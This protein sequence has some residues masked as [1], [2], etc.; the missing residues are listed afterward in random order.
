MLSSLLPSYLVLV[1]PGCVNQNSIGDRVDFY[2]H[3]FV[4]Y[5]NYN[6][7]FLMITLVWF[8]V[9]VCV[10]SFSF[11]CHEFNRTRNS[12]HLF[13]GLNPALAFHCGPEIPLSCM[14]TFEM[15]GDGH[16]GLL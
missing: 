13:P 5:W 14:A 15:W 6:G 10:V 7:H 9:C 4:L 2:K 8:G 16:L 3:P 11:C 1:S 12:S